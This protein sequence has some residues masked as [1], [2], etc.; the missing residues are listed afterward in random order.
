MMAGAA[1]FEPGQWFRAH[2]TADLQQWLGVEA[3]SSRFA[4]KR[5]VRVLCTP[6]PSF[7]AEFDTKFQLVEFT[8]GR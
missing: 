5:R 6:G 7:V 2:A 1:E 3:V 8:G 4:G